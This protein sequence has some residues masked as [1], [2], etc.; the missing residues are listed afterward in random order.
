MKVK[1]VRIF[2]KY[3]EDTGRTSVTVEG[4]DVRTGNLGDWA[5]LEALLKILG[6]EVEVSVYKTDKAF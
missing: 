4:T 3:G 5:N 6:H 2:N 1:I